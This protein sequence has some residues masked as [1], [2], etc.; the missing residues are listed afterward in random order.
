MDGN[1]LLRTLIHE[2]R[3]SVSRDAVCVSDEIEDAVM[4]LEWAIARQTADPDGVFD[5][6]NPAR[7]IYVAVTQRI[8]DVD[9]VR[10]PTIRYFFS[11]KGDGTAILHELH[12]E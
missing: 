5:L 6:V 10:I 1:I 9:G 8:E 12:A 11:L 3:C 7:G 4:G 2:D